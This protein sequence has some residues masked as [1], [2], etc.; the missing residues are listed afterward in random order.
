MR[1]QFHISKAD[2]YNDN[3]SELETALSFLKKERHVHLQRIDE[4]E[5]EIIGIKEELR[6]RREKQRR[7]QL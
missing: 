6:A 2:I 3:D 1:T 4:I 5:T 7:E